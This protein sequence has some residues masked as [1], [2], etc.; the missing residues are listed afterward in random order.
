M[1]VEEVR[2]LQEIE[3]NYR[4][5]WLTDAICENDTCNAAKD[6]VFIYRDSEHLSHEGSTFLG[7]KMDFYGILSA[8][9]ATHGGALQPSASFELGRAE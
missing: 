4:V 1:Q 2:L 9:A 6:G 3:K 8:T 5:V 7:L